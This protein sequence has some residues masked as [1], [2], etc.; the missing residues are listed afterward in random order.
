MTEQ[1][2]AEPA[3]EQ[4]A[5]PRRWWQISRPATPKPKRPLLLRLFGMSLWGTLKLTLL[6][7]L[8]G[9]IMLAM[10]FDPTDPNFDTTDAISALLANALATSKWAITNFWKPA[11]TGAS[12]ILPLWILWRLVTLPFRK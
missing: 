11:L 5:K 10:Q 6:C 9:F 2:N 4:P 8:T 3:P 1:T 7:I 12:V